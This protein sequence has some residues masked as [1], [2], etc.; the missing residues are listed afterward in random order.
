MISVLKHDKG[1]LALYMAHRSALVDYARPI[2]GCRA[3]AEDVVQEAYLRFEQVT[4]DRFLE[5]PVGFLYRIVRNLALDFARRLMREARLVDPADAEGV[6]EDRPSPEAEA[7]HRDQLRAVMTALA[8][9]P[10]RTRIAVAMHRIEGRT[11][12]EI[13]DHLGISIGLAHSLVYDGLDHCRQNLR[14]RS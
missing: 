7:L 13:A 5:E 1:K 3:R 2:V 8:Q 4:P 6:A 14:A 12:K 9:L 11:L 10:E